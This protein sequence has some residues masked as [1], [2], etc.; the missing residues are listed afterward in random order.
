MSSLVEF[1]QSAWPS[2]EEV[3][4]IG[5]GAILLAW[6]QLYFA[7][8]FRNWKKLRAG[9]SRKLFHLQ[10]F[11]TASWLSSSG[12]ITPLCIYGTSVL[13]WVGI[14]LIRADGLGRALI[15]DEDAPHGIR[16]VIYPG[17]ATLLGGLACHAWLPTGAAVGLLIVGVCD[18]IAEPIGLKWGRHPYRLVWVPWL[19]NATRTLEGSLSIFISAL[20][21]LLCYGALPLQST[22][23][24]LWCI[25]G[26]LGVTIVEA[27]SPHGADN[28]TL[29]LASAAWVVHAYPQ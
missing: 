20:I 27:I 28:F 21:I 6:A 19:K 10:V 22:D 15:R 29:Q 4:L 25:I 11:L 8:E 24:L 16:Y 26:A 2:F 1:F 13:I 17:V 9:Y 14:S 3:W 12:D 18:A 7:A 5:P 23:F